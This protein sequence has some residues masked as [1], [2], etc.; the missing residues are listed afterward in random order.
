M[1]Y[2]SAI[3]E[4]TDIDLCDICMGVKIF[5]NNVTYIDLGETVKRKS[6]IFDASLFFY[7]S[8]DCSRCDN[9]HC[10]LEGF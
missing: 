3:K 9:Y 4:A 2:F 10:K 6:I 7:C 8:L 1:D 5:D